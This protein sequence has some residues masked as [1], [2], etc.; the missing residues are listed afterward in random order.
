MKNESQNNLKSIHLKRG[1]KIVLYTDGIFECTNDQEKIWGVRKF[2][3]VLMES[4]ESAPAELQK[5]VVEHAFDFFNGQPPDD[6]ITL[7]VAKVKD[8]WQ[9]VQLDK[10]V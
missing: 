8:E 5:E 4:A 7:V 3:K 9:P 10:A 2:K 1:D 6:D